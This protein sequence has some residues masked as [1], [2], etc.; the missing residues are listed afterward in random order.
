MRLTLLPL[1]LI[2]SVSHAGR[3][4]WFISTRKRKSRCLVVS[5]DVIGVAIVI[6]RGRVE[7]IN[8]NGCRKYQR[9]IYFG[10]KS[11]NKNKFNSIVHF[12]N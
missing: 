4:A 5:A 9:N 6:R 12:F 7:R 8:G 1:R 10:R 3:R 2:N 11:K